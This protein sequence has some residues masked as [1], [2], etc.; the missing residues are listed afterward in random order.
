MDD[1]GDGDDDDQDEDD[2]PPSRS[3]NLKR[4]P[5][6]KSKPPQDIVDNVRNRFT[7]SVILT[8]IFSFRWNMLLV[9][10]CLS[11]NLCPCMV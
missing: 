3:R 2:D 10:V 6:G 11:L 7:D 1:I 8:F 4:G 5:D 9:I